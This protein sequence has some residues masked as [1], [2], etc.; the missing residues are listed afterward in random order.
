VYEEQ[1]ALP[2]PGQTLRWIESALGKGTRVVSVRRMLGGSSTAIHAVD[3]R[4]RR[5]KTERL[6]MRR[7]I[8]P[9]WKY[10][11]LAR[12]E[13]NVLE[14]LERARYPAPRLVAFDDGPHETDV[15]A[16]L[17]TRLPGRVEISPERVEPWLRQMAEALPS[18]HAIRLSDDMR[19]YR[20]YYDPRTRRAPAW[21]KQPEA[22]RAV[23]DLARTRQPRTTPRPIHRDYHPG[24]ILWQRGKLAG[25][26]D[27]INAC[28]GP[29]QVDIAHCRVNLVRLY[30]LD[31]ADR[32]LAAYALA[33]GMS[34]EDY[35]P[36]WDAMGVVDSG[37]SPQITAP[38]LAPRGLTVARM[39]SRLDAFAVAIAGRG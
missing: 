38:A 4:D 21:S 35:D 1:V 36:Y 27:W 23:I 37:H 39:R 19:R 24:N 5:G 33:A 2:V 11:G 3:V 7:F 32:F 17:M 29:L 15:R 16:L 8:R 9:N 18:I 31:V 34:V 20:P 26:I 6:V 22:W 10:P 12:R 25:V 30:G 14:A 13:A 28:A